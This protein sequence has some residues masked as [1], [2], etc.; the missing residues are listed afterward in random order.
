M[1]LE[2]DV[3][4]IINARCA[5]CPG[6]HAATKAGL[7]LPIGDGFEGIRMLNHFTSPLVVIPFII[8]HLAIIYAVT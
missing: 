8:I 4:L 3:S 6:I 5:R 1:K 7:L 2:A